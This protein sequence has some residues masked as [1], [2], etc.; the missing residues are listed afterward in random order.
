MS[1]QRDENAD[2]QAKVAIQE[3]RDFDILK[4]KVTQNHEVQLKKLEIESSKKQSAQFE[5][6]KIVERIVIAVIKLPIILPLIIVAGI[7]WL[8]DRELPADL[9]EFIDL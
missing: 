8:K 4:L 9:S 7:L 2:D 1:M 5:R 6:H 3:T